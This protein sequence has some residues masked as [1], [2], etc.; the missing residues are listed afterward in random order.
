MPSS[1]MPTTAALILRGSLITWKRK[2]GRPG[3]RCA[4]GELHTTPALSYSVGGVTQMVMLHDAVLPVVQAALD[5][6]QRAQA[7]L[8]RRVQASV[9]TLRAQL[10][11]EKAAARRGR[12]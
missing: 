1:R 3:C 5:R 10:A 12:R 11:R 9:T 6:Y 2:C 7:F 4:R 8:D